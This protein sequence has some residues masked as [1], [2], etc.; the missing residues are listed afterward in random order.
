MTIITRYLAF[1]FLK[2][3]A[4]ALGSFMVLYTSVDFLEKI[5]QFVA[6]DIGVGTIGIFFLSQLPKIMVIM[7]PVATLVGVLITLALMARASEIVA[8]KAG[9]VSLYRLSIPFL[10]TGLLIC[11]AMFIVS[12]QVASRATTLA[13]SIWEGQVRNRLKTPTVVRDVWLKGVLQVQYMAS[14]DEPSGTVEGIRLIFLDDNMRMLRRLEAQ[15]GHFTNNKFYLEDVFEKLYSQKNETETTGGRNFISSLHQNMVLDNWPTPPPGLGRTDQNSEE[16]SVKQ[17]RQTIKRL[18]KEGFGPV[19]QRV[20]LQFKFSFAFLPLIMVVVGLPLGF[21][22]EKG[23]GVA[24]SLALG[25]GLSFV[26]LIAMELA[27]YLGYSGLLPPVV[28]AWLP[29]L[30]YLLLGAYL[31]SYL[32]Q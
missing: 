29:N 9:G 26:Y 6:K 5:S 2:T 20:D 27:R 16:M 30:F 31:F 10:T 7:S 25:L 13:N 15:K 22:K 24:L 3:W 19:K 4:L 11:L 1:S 17:L 18:S 14:Y 23:G 21:W 8:F 28:A 32:R 12:D